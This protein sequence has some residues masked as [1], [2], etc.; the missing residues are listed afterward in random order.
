MINNLARMIFNTGWTCA[1]KIE[2][3]IS[4]D[5]FIFIWTWFRSSKNANVIGFEFVGDVYHVAVS[6]V[7]LKPAK[8]IPFSKPNKQKYKVES[9][10]PI[11]LLCCYSKLFEQIIVM[12]L[13]SQLSHSVDFP[14][15]QFGFTKGRSTISAISHLVNKMTEIKKN[16]EIG[17]VL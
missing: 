11:S 10:K 17:Y 4:I 12:D 3:V 14:V 15:N 9:L 7:H 5:I 2:A 8:L 16:K 13:K 1:G 6:S